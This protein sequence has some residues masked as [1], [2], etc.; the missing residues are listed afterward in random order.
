MTDSLS[1]DT[2]IDKRIGKA[3]TTMSRLSKRVWSNKKL[4]EHTKVQVYRACILSTLLYGSEAWTLHARQ[5]RKLHTFHTRCLRRIFNV[6]WQDKVPNNAILE[7]AQLP[8]MYSILKERRLRWLGHVTR[9]NDGRIPKDLLY[10]ELSSGKR[11]VGRPLLRY[12]DVCKRDL[13]AIRLDLNTWEGLDQDRNA[14]R[15][16]I[17]EG[18]DQFEASVAEKQDVLHQRR[19][20]SNLEPQAATHHTCSVCGRDCHSRIGLLSH[21]R[22]CSRHLDPSE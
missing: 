9:M 20:A 6:T 7:R 3:S 15:H 1:L 18:L 2:E 21:S 19:K 17:H 10:G 4:T 16:A 22:K 5:E 14:W 13:Q 8:S 11:A 12:K